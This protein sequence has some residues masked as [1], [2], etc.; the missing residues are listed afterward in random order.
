MYGFLR[1]Q[2]PPIPPRLGARPPE[3]QYSK[4]FSRG[5]H[6]RFAR[7]LAFP[8]IF[9]C[10]KQNLSM[11]QTN[12]LSN[13]LNSIWWRCKREKKGCFDHVCA[14]IWVAHIHSQQERTLTFSM[15]TQDWKKMSGSW[16][17]AAGDKFWGK[18]WFIHKNQLTHTTNSQS[19]AL[20]KF[21]ACLHRVSS[22]TFPYKGNSC[23]KTSSFRAKTFLE[24][25]SHENSK[26]MRP[27]F[28]LKRI[29]EFLVRVNNSTN[30]GARKKFQKMGMCNFCCC[31]RK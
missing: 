8:N 1:T 19:R 3:P 13:T 17:A 2:N 15:A 11:Y 16:A 27:K 22:C 12:V 6:K 28:S 25:F 23:Q 29:S 4:T 14:L 7:M 5:S 9:E 18:Q 20:T 21:L 31:L 24:D 26:Y 10:L 30:N